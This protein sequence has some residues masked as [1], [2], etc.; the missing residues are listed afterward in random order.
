MGAGA[1]VRGEGRG[2]ST[3]YGGGG[4]GATLSEPAPGGRRGTAALTRGACVKAGWAERLFARS[5]DSTLRG[6][7]RECCDSMGRTVLARVSPDT[8]VTCARDSQPLRI[9]RPRRARLALAARSSAAAARAGRCSCV[10][11]A[12][13]T[14]SGDSARKWTDRQDH[15]QCARNARGL[16]SNGGRGDGMEVTGLTC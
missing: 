2:V 13:G 6:K 10:R 1:L 12:A 15:R 14:G 11:S 16:E 4:A 8:L 5:G 3:Q 7:K 9:P